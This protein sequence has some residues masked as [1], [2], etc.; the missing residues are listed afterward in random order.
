MEVEVRL[1]AQVREIVGVDRIGLELPEPACIGAIR[2]GLIARIPAL[3][4]WK[5]LLLFAVNGRYADDSTPIEPG[6][7]IACFPP[8]GGG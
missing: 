1:F 6:G 3:A 7:E 5:H 2:E 8:V 4:A